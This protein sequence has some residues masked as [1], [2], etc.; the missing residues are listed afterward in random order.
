MGILNFFFYRLHITWFLAALLNIPGFLVV[1]YGIR[2]WQK[3]A[4]VAYLR[5]FRANRMGD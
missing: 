3:E 5:E 1:V 2:F 4:I